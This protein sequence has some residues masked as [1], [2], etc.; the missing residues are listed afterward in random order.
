MPFCK[1]VS[2]ACG[3]VWLCFRTQDSISDDNV[4][5]SSANDSYS[6]EFDTATET[7]THTKTQTAPTQRKNAL[8]TAV[9]AGGSSPGETR[10]SRLAKE[11]GLD[12][13]GGPRSPKAAIVT[14]NGTAGAARRGES[15]S[16]SEDSFSMTYSGKTLVWSA[17]KCVN[18]K[19]ANSEK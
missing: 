15:G 5:N 14:R 9:P 7:Q 8:G 17:P 12:L 16:E 10:L 19:W 6:H 11:K 1:F 18:S 2:D 4:I 13:S 3:C